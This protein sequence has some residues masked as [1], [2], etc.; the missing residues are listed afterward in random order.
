MTWYMTDGGVGIVDSATLFNT[1][2]TGENSDKMG[3]PGGS[4]AKFTLQENEDGSLDI[5]Y[6]IVGSVEEWSLPDPTEPSS[7][8]S[9]GSFYFTDAL[10][11]GDIHLYAWDASGNSL[12]GEWPGQS[13]VQGEMNPYNQMVYTINVPA[14]AAGVIVNGTGGQTAN[15]T[16]F[17]PGGGGYYVDASKTS[18]N[19][20]GK[21]V[22]DPIPWDV[23]IESQPVPGNRVT[24]NATGFD[25][26]GAYFYA[27]TWGSSDGHWVVAD[28]DS[29]DVAHIYF[30]NLDSK[31]IFVRMNPQAGSN[32]SW[33]YKWNQTGDL[34]TQQGGTFTLTGW[35][36][37][38]HW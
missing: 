14:G 28:A 24:L 8:G 9:D 30:S 32:P 2:I 18:T 25:N 26:D 23:Q 29:S 11:W 1:S 34:D 3:V 35:G 6:E 27:W 16:D 13:G 7:G 10:G 19:E 20:F 37:D 15:I 22:Y 21:T 31:V 38:G 5:S 12:T 17:N 36:L 4:Q 33:D